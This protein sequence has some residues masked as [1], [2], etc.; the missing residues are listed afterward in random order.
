M[1]DATAEAADVGVWRTARQLARTGVVGMP[2]HHE[3]IG[4]LAR[5]EG[6]RARPRRGRGGGT[7]Y[8][9]PPKLAAAVLRHEAAVTPAAAPVPEDP[10]TRRNAL[11]AAY[12][13]A[14][15]GRQAIA[16]ARFA[17]VHAIEQRLASGE[18]RGLAIRAVAMESNRSVTCLRRWWR[19]VQGH[20]RSDWLAALLPAPRPGRPRRQYDPRIDTIY[21]DQYGRLEQ[22]SAQLAYDETVGLCRRLGITE[23]PPL[24]TLHRNYFRATTHLERVYLRQ[25]D[26][27]LAEAFPPLQRMVSHLEAMEIINGDQHLFDAD[28]F[29]WPDG[30]TTN[31]L[32]VVSWQDVYS[33]L[34]LARRYGATANG[35]LVRLSLW[36]TFRTH[37]LPREIVIDNGSE[38]NTLWFQELCGLLGI[39]VANTLPYNGRAKPIERL[40]RDWA[41]RIAR[42]SYFRAAWRGNR[43]GTRPDYRQRRVIP[44]AEAIAYIEEQIEALNDRPGRRTETAGGRLSAREAY[45]QRRATSTI[46]MATEAQLQL[47]LLDRKEVR[48]SRHGTITLHETRYYARELHELAGRIVAVRY[49]PD[50]LSQPV[51]VCYEGALV[52]EATV[53]GGQRFNDRVSAREYHR[54]KRAAEKHAQRA[55][56]ARRQAARVL[57]AQV[58][59]LPRLAVPAPAA[60]RLLAPVFN[61]PKSV[62]E[63]ERDRLP[64]RLAEPARVLD[65][66]EVLAG[67][68]L[69]GQV[70]ETER[71]EPIDLARL[72]RQ[73]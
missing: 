64:L 69:M 32:V 29:L 38:F 1:T 30:K 70:Q 62:E 14:K 57:L 22:P 3:D 42:S 18:P 58:E 34:S 19:L 27:A 60:A 47:L 23:I 45:N 43:P 20:E 59:P 48:V 56:E 2:T 66:A 61:M 40:H 46:R 8:L 21:A 26:D 28:D 4:R 35:D 72:M 63:L 15:Q 71:V 37:G 31:R 33:R 17:L 52:A 50:D 6:W 51:Q 41:Q 67:L 10:I 24:R 12:R 36:E 7:E 68:R 73:A 5:R 44:V 53:W 65:P 16:R 54:K 55:A 9:L 25:G 11:W 13:R 39:R 49:N